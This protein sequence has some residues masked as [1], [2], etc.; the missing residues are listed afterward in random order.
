M[1]SSVGLD[2]W[3]GSEQLELLDSSVN[4]ESDMPVDVDVAMMGHFEEDLLNGT[5]TPLTSLAAFDNE[6]LFE[7][8]SDT[9]KTVELP[10]TESRK[11]AIHMI[12]VL[13][14]QARGI[15]DEIERLKA[16][17]GVALETSITQGESVKEAPADDFER[18]VE[19]A[20]KS[21]DVDYWL[22]DSKIDSIFGDENDDAGSLSGDSN[23]D[24]SIASLLVSPRAGPSTFGEVLLQRKTANPV[25][26]FGD[27]KKKFASDAILNT[28]ITSTKKQ[29]SGTGKS[30]SK[31]TNAS[32]TNSESL[33]T[34]STATTATTTTTTTTGGNAQP[35]T[36]PVTKRA[37][38]GETLAATSPLCKRP[39][40]LF[41]AALGRR[42]MKT[43]PGVLNVTT[44]NTLYSQMIG[45][46]SQQRA[47]ISEHTTQRTKK[48]A[49]RWT[50][51]QDA[52][53]RVAVQ[54][55][56]GQNWKAIARLVP[57][58]DHVQCLQRWK[59]VLQPGLVKGM[60]SSEED[61][62]LLKFM[63]SPHPK[64][65]ADIAAK[66][67]GRTAKQCRERWSLNLDPSINRGAWTQE[68]DELLI[69]LHAQ[70]GNRW[71]EIKRHLNGRTENGVKTRFKSIERARSKDK[72]TNWTPELEKQ[73]HDIAVRFDC[74]IDEM[75]KHLPRALRGIS[76][77]AMRDHCPLL[78][79]R[80][81]S[82]ATTLPPTTTK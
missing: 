9:A 76:S 5:E 17:S 23:L 37:L 55:H 15:Q 67:P 39:R 27:Y 6:P 71:A 57:D 3:F 13:Q 29:A 33:S 65:W 40:T 58:R 78:R 54:K 59:K 52:E 10:S 12:N 64:N 46:R 80:C 50:P 31:K 30:N 70:L 20:I 69:K 62:L 75:A 66:V 26:S 53:L 28:T 43:E 35:A 60:W 72:E 8:R 4:L 11:S 34:T 73:L 16:S 1:D 36:L 44:P 21:T 47:A 38:E 74:R 24:T 56:N 2:N 49:R 42:K 45:K 19:E 79:E 68:E 77:Q 7:P 51:E 32:T 25:Q 63:S 41:K 48:E 18:I 14:E 22:D 81:S 61:E 82:A